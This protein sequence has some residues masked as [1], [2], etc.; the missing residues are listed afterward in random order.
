MSCESI[1]QDYIDT[2]RNNYTKKIFTVVKYKPTSSSTETISSFDPKPVVETVCT[3]ISSAKTAISTA[4]TYLFND[5]EI[6]NGE[7]QNF[8]QLNALSE[9][10]R[11]TPSYSFS[12]PKVYTDKLDY[13]YTCGQLYTSY[14][15]GVDGTFLKTLYGNVPDE[16]TAICSKYQNLYDKFVPDTS[17]TNSKPKI[18]QFWESYSADFIKEIKPYELTFKSLASDWNDF[19]NKVHEY[20]ELGVDAAK[21]QAVGFVFEHSGEREEQ[22]LPTMTDV[23]SSCQNKFLYYDNLVEDLYGLWV[24]SAAHANTIYAEESEWVI[25]SNRLKIFSGVLLE[26]IGF[27]SA[28]E[29]IYKNLLTFFSK[30]NIK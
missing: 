18:A 25:I 17:E 13:S 12:N 2:I 23:F 22:T 9:M 24:Q 4:W 26:H 15:K 5:L 14:A 10:F 3:G 27:F 1:L 20:K 21:K 6:P 7:H 11:K 30:Y 16:I 19:Y 8:L 29:K 28:A